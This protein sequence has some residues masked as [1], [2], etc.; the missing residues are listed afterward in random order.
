MFRYNIF[1]KQYCI[2]NQR[3]GQRNEK[4]LH[5][6]M[7]LILL[8]ISCASLLQVQ[9]TTV[10]IKYGKIEG[11]TTSYPNA[12]GP[13]KSVSKFL[14]VPFAS[15]PI[16][17]LRVK[18]PQPLKEWKP[19]V[20]QA[21]RHG[22]ICW[23]P[24]TYEF[25]IKAFAQNFSY[26]EDCLYLDVYTPNI[27]FNLPVM[28]YIH[29]GGYEIG[30]AIKFPSDILALQGVVVVV[31]QYRLGPFGFLTTGDSAA[32]GNFGMLDQVEALKWVKENIENFGGN[33][34]KV[35]IFG[36]SAGGSS[37][38]LH[39]L[40]PLSKGLFHQAIAESGVDL[41]IWATQSVSFGLHYAKELAKKLDCTTSNSRNMINCIRAKEDTDIE[42]AR[43]STMA[44]FRF[45]DY[46]PWAPVVDKNFLHDTPQNLRKKNE[47][48]KVPL[49]ISFNSHEGAS[50]LGATVNASFGLME[51]VENGVRPGLFESFLTKFAHSL[52]SG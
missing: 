52:N 7:S 41:S 38:C 32:P 21:K 9:P 36:A 40:S 46:L 16:G 26:S 20:R 13:F 49:M 30:T 42:K 4:L 5:K 44:N 33:P 31:I 37:V 19:K 18:A 6:A 17:E 14:G 1:D 34:G 39:L 12:S 29:G 23:Q 22:N 15:P 50:S 10:S 24:K 27:S 3:E 47:F 43:E 45:K 2:Q 8:V 51:S 28:V 11:L 48:H 35:T 25:M